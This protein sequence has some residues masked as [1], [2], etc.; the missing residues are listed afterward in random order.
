MT[1]TKAKL[2]TSSLPFLP[3]AVGGAFGQRPILFL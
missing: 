1:M 3:P 2:F